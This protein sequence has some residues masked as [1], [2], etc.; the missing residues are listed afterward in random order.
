MYSLFIVYK[1]FLNKPNNFT[2]RVYLP[3]PPKGLHRFQLFFVCAYDSW[4][5]N[6]SPLIY[7]HI[8]G[9]THKHLFRFMLI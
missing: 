9:T 4:D 7:Q 3:V 6:S 5:S 2:V 1:P 8:E